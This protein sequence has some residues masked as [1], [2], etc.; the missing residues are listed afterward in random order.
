MQ[1]WKVRHI[2]KK[3]VKTAEHLQELETNSPQILGEDAELWQAI[4][5][6]QFPHSRTKDYVPKNPAK[7]HSV[8]NKYKAEHEARLE[9][10]RETLRNSM[11][12]LQKYKK[13]NTSKCVDHKKLPK[14]PRD[15]GM[16]AHNGGVP[17]KGRGQKS[18]PATLTWSTGS[19]T[20]MTDGRGVMTRARREAK[21]MTSRS[22]LITPTARLNGRSGQVKKAPAGMT[23]AY[24]IANQPALKVLTRHKAP[25]NASGI[26]GPSL[27]E[28]EERLRA[29][30]NSGKR[31][32]SA[33]KEPYVDSSD[34][35]I[36]GGD[37]I[38]ELFDEK[39]TKAAVKAT[40]PASALR[41][42]I[43]P[44]APSSRIASSSPPQRSG[45]PMVQKCN[46]TF[47]QQ[48]SRTSSETPSRT[49]TPKPMMHA[50]RRPADVDIFNRGKKPRR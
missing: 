2:L 26:S 14:I 10:D 31:D 6:K 19:R 50:R 17:L 9:H 42:I 12:A 49:V 16:P 21:E 35:E 23:Q 3:T 22:K 36:I 13:D 48:P 40:R 47:S 28:R 15:Y 18:T 45:A 20:K 41:K 46:N 27:E 8:Y 37:D 44:T 34:D 39:E 25:Q 5:A 38:D 4:I 32:S 29:A 1:Y 11:N 24:R 33:L 7:W 30:I 43:K